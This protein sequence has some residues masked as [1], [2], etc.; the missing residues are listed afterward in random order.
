M[1]DDY[2]SPF[3]QVDPSL[4]A[5]NTQNPIPNNTTSAG[6]ESYGIQSNPNSVDAEYVVNPPTRVMS[7]NP[8]DRKTTNIPFIW[9]QKG[10]KF[11]IVFFVYIIII[12]WDFLKKTFYI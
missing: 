1:D 7:P 10:K 5:Q 3:Q 9:R 11:L 8:D 6:P 2:I 4:T 12:S